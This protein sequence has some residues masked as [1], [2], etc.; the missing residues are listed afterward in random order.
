MVP[1][2]SY[3]PWAKSRG[4]GLLPQSWVVV[5][6]FQD[7]RLIVF[8]KMKLQIFFES[9]PPIFY[10]YLF[11][12]PLLAFICLDPFSF[13]LLQSSLSSQKHNFKIASKQGCSPLCVHIHLRMPS[14]YV[15]Q[16]QPYSSWQLASAAQ[17]LQNL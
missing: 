13:H 5:T 4:C 10:S 17:D 15:K 1:N 6:V 8:R 9:F 11:Y 12:T 3:G 7:H 14:V 16:A 2:L